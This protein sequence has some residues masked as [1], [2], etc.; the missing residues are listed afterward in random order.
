MTQT[1]KIILA[2][3]SPQRKR[4]LEQIDMNFR[5]IRPSVKENKDI[6]DP[7]MRVKTNALMKAANVAENLNDGLV[8]GVD[9][10]VVIDN[11]ILGKPNDMREAYEMIHALSARTHLVYSGIAII[12][13]KDGII[14]VD[15]EET[16]VTMR[17]IKNNEIL[18]YVKSGEPLNKAGA[19][20]AQ[21]LG[22]LLIKRIDGCFFNIVGLP[23]SLLSVLLKRFGYSH[24]SCTREQ[25]KNKVPRDCAK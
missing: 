5:I 6:K 9:T 21:G 10:V 17:T 11:Q 24:L 14:E 22:A 16:S 20:A 15:H 2:S 1:F 18:A 3:A 7:I 19:Y 4:L 23:I 13:S 12:N 8:I 25:S